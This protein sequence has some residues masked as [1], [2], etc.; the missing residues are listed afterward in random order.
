MFQI[1]N[2][3][4]VLTMPTPTEPGTPGFFTDGNTAGGSGPTILPAEFMNTVMMEIINVV[5]SAGLPLDKVNNKQMLEALNSLYATKSHLHKEYALKSDLEKISPMD[6]MPVGKLE[7]WHSSI[8]PTGG[9]W[10]VV[11]TVFDPIAFPELAT[12]FPSG[13]AG[14]DAS[15]RFLR[16][17][18]NST[19]L[20]NWQQQEDAIRNITGSFGEMMG[21]NSTAS[22]IFTST[23]T[24]AGVVV[25]SANQRV[26]V[27]L[28][29]SAQLPTASEIRPKGIVLRH[30]IIKAKP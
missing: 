14:A 18:G 24:G 28:D 22:G 19:T 1:D 8:L 7:L 15:D 21:V 6:L 30:L 3:S 25:A 13:V 16:V 2:Q 12:L 20:T 10:M 29:I 23:N 4:A 11:G 27:D 9:K 5:K 26:R 17:M